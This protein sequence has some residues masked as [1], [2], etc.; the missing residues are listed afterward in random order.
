MINSTLSRKP[1]EYITT[2]WKRIESSEIASRFTTGVFWSV[3]GTVILRLLNLF[4]FIF[5]ARLLGREVYGEFGMIRSTINMFVVFGSM[6]MGLTATKYVAVLRR[7]DPNHA[8][9]VIA[10]CLIISIIFTLIISSIG[11]LYSPYVASHILKAPHI[12]IE[13]RIAMAVILVSAI[14][15]TLNGILSGFEAFKSIAKINIWTGIF[16]FP[17]LVGS[18]FL[19]GMRGAVIAMC[20]NALGSCFLYAKE[21]RSQVD[22]FN[23]KIRWNK[24]HKELHI[25]RKF[26]LPALLSGI[27]VSPVLWLCNAMLV[28]QPGGYG[29]MGIFDAANQWLMI[30]IFLPGIVSQI[31]LPM[32]SNFLSEKKRTE[33]IKFLKYSIAICCGIVLSISL[34]ILTLS[35][36]IMKAYGPGFA[37]GHWILVIL[38]VVGILISL[39]NVIGQS[40][41]SNERMWIGFMLNGLW[42]LVILLCSY[43]F[44]EWG[45][46]AMGLAWAYLVAYVVHSIGIGIYTYRLVN[47]I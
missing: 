31:S 8:G 14:I 7:T 27:M 20:L 23:I 30:V 12:T 3:A 2:K 38:V 43:I 18:I 4:A 47:R 28:N 17:L 11:Y 25:L 37:H 44:V 22:R 46:G 29:Q 15:G 41:A 35:K 32:L 6:G 33:Y 39:N 9:R 10:L 21:I 16:S 1:K 34:P 45:L 42:A 26:S 24:V 5:I 36:F 40:L 19:A 13:L